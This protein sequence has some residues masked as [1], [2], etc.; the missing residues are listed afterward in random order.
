MMV[1]IY[2]L[3]NI[4]DSLS[5]ESAT[6]LIRVSTGELVAHWVELDHL[7]DFDQEGEYPR[8]MITWPAA[9]LESGERYIVAMHD[10]KH[11]NGTSVTSSAAFDS[12]KK[13]QPSVDV[14]SSRIQYYDKQVFPQIEATGLSRDELQL[15]WDF[16]V[17]T[18]KALTKRFVSMR[19]DAFSRAP[20]SGPSYNVTSVQDNYKP[21]IG[22]YI[23][24]TI[25]VPWYLNQVDPGLDVHLVEGADG[26]PKY[27]QTVPVAFSVLVPEAFTNGTITEP[28]RIIQYG[29]KSLS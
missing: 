16:T 24:G 19:D 17:G 12:L 2:R 23:Q 21:G 29:R 10:L 6:V 14:P 4:H 5:T 9:R 26:L 1:N 22:K 8:A 18:Q 11:V 15:A 13:G 3:W 25:D 7:S 20:S 27:Q 28:A